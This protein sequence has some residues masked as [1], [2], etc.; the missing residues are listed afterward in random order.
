M[1][2][3]I[4][5]NHLLNTSYLPSLFYIFSLALTTFQNILHFTYYG[6]SITIILSSFKIG[7][8]V[9]LTLSIACN[10]LHSRLSIK[11][12]WSKLKIENSCFSIPLNQIGS[13]VKYY[14]ETIFTGCPWQHTL[15]ILDVATWLLV[16]FCWLL[17]DML[18]SSKEIMCNEIIILT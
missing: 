12:C 14:I 13:I 1:K 5:F 4:N 3:N 6:I 16:K 11:T 9:C 8:F 10:L 15:S 2:T 7:I 18:Y 17:E